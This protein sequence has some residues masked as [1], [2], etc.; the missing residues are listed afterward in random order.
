M[1]LPTRT[2]D[3]AAEFGH[4]SGGPLTP[5]P[6]E[7]GSGEDARIPIALVIGCARSGTSILGELLAAHPRVHYLFEAQALWRSAGPGVSG[8]HRLVAEHA[9]PELRRSIRRWFREQQGSAALIVEKTPRNVLR[10]PFLRAVFPE[11]SLVHIVR[12]GRDV[13]CSM[14][15]AIGGATWRHLRPPSWQRLFAEHSG[16]IR[17]ALAWKETIEIALRDLATERHLQVRYEDLVGRPEEVAREVLAYVGLADAPE[18]RRFCSKV[19]DSTANSYHAAHQVKWYRDDHARR[20]GRWRENMT[21]DEQRAVNDL[22]AP[23]LRR[24]GYPYDPSVLHP[25]HRVHQ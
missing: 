23:L 7:L 20:T 17:C 21:V 3:R 11:A 2:D 25:E 10:I 5:S 14:L 8:S 15:P 12:D 6:S 18:V 1:S 19:Q 9:T 22:L 24:L 4:S 13:A 16:V